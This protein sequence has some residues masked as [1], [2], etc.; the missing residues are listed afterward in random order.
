MTRT[1]RL[2]ADDWVVAAVEVIALRGLTNLSVEGLARKLG[3]TKGSFYWHFSD[4]AELVAVALEMWEQQAT[5]DLI[6]ELEAIDDPAERLRVLFEQ[7]FGDEVHGLVDA[8]LVTQVDDPTVG[9]VVRRVT[10]RRIAFLEQVF[11]ELGLT[12]AGAASRARIVYSTYVGH[13][14]VRRCAPEDTVLSAPASDYRRQLLALMSA[15]EPMGR[16]SRA[17]PVQI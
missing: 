12:P 15:D 17:S 5:L 4:R 3:V 2:S 7:S 6:A 11:G 8:A 14:L 10:A 13:F 1:Q 16:T 9:P